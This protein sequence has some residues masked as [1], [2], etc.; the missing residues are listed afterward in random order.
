MK[1]TVI[2]MHA[3]RWQR[4]ANPFKINLNVCKNSSQSEIVENLVLKG[5]NMTAGGANKQK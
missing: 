1:R 4:N 5:N 2:H 3:I